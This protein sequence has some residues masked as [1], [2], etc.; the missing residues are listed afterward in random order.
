ML[1]KILKIIL[2][3]VGKKTVQ[4]KKTKSV[5]Y[6]VIP[7]K[8]TKRLSAADKKLQEA[9]RFIRMYHRQQFP[10]CELVITEVFRHPSK[11]KKLYDQGRSK[12]GKTV[13]NIDGYKKKGKHNYYPSKAIDVA[14]RFLG[15]RKITWELG[16]YKPLVKIVGRVGGEMGIKLVSGGSWKTLKD[17]P[18]IQI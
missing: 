17:Y 12:P 4:P 9:F 14:V 16:Y 13:T 18:H 2:E 7:N 3:L 8:S 15:S 11:Q 10:D 5:T 1:K 6:G